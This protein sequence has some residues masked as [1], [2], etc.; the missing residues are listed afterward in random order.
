MPATGNEVLPNSK[1]A[2]PEVQSDQKLSSKI[3]SWVKRHYL[4]VINIALAIYVFLPMMAPVLMKTGHTN[5]ADVVYKLYKPLCHQLAY[6]SFFLFGE[7]MVYPRD[8]AGI[9]DLK[10]YEEV[11]GFDSQDQLTAIAF[12]GNEQLGYKIALCQRDIAIYLSLLLF[13]LMFSITGRK[14]KPLPWLAWIILALVPIGLDGFSQLISQM[15]IS[16]LGWLS[17]RESTPVLRV[18]S[19]VMFGWFTAWFGLPSIEEIMNEKKPSNEII[20]SPLKGE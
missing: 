10:S 17:V 2:S 15:E 11:T 13:G 14:L 16:F 8:L 18:L 5:A 19:G 7:Q 6:R 1:S 4:A 3:G 12:R 9:P 20:S